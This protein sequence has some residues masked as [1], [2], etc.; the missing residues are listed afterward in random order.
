MGTKP[1]QQL[2]RAAEGGEPGPFADWQPSWRNP[3]ASGNS[4]AARAG[5]DEPIP[6]LEEQLAVLQREHNELRQ[7]IFAA[8]QAQ[9]RLCA[10]R[11]ARR[12]RFEIASEIFPVRH[13]SG[14]FNQVLDLGAT[15]GLAVGDIAGKGL[16]AGLWL[17]HLA[18]LVRTHLGSSLDLSEAVTAINEELW[19][20]QP[21]APMVALFLARLDQQC[22]ELIYCNA[23]QSPAVVLRAEGCVEFLEVGG[24]MLGG[25]S[26]ASFPSGRVV[27]G[28]GDALISYSDGI[29]EC[30]NDRGEEFGAERLV[31]ASQNAGHS[32]AAHM[33]YSLLGAAQDFAGTH[34]REDDLTLM[35]ARRLE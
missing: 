2:Q 14:D 35:V 28:R 3:A 8:A 4:R 24:P 15:T 27:L 25:I 9:R 23:G 31:A 21:E 1:Q 13:L 33:L 30:R 18:G 17:A 10:P 19:K 26:G 11:Q 20:M 5:Q 32:S 29:V 16:T 34:A 7:A 6:L 12:G 22:G